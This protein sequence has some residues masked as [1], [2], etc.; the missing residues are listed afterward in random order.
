M[1]QKLSGAETPDL[2]TGNTVD[3][4]TQYDPI[5]DIKITGVVKNKQT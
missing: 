2:V 3:Q 1:E 5:D 4:G